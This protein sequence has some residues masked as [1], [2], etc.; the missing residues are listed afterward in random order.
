ML[1]RYEHHVAVMKRLD[2]LLDDM[3]VAC[4]LSH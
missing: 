2:Q 3:P 1:D 4:L